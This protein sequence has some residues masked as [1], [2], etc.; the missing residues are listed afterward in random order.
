M[1]RIPLS[2]AQ[3]HPHPWTLL[4]TANVATIPT[5]GGRRRWLAAV[6]TALDQPTGQQSLTR[7][8]V[9]PATAMA[10]ATLDAQAADHRTGR[11]VATAHATLARAL[12]VCS[13][14]IQ[15]GRQVLIDLG[16]ATVVAAGRYLT[17]AERQQAAAAG[18][19]QIRAA[20]TRVLTL[21]HHLAHV[22]LPRRGSS[23]PHTSRQCM[24][25]NR[26]LTRAKAA[27]KRTIRP[28]WLQRLAAR[29]A[30]RLPWLAT[31]HIGRLCD[32]LDA[33]P[34]SPDWTATDIIDTLDAR[35]R[36]LGLLALPPSSQHHPA[37]LLAHQLADA[38][39]HDINAHANRL[40]RH[41]QH[42]QQIATRAQQIAQTRADAQAHAAYMADA[43]AR[44]R[45]RAQREQLRARLREVRLQRRG[46]NGNVA[47][48]QVSDQAHMIG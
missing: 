29:L 10:I 22:H 8:H 42:Q 17:T 23:T 32:A 33:L 11:S 46:H 19:H 12:R 37:A 39:A 15:R 43:A 2:Q 14:T 1:A 31:G 47:S 13:R 36:S 48:K 34:I 26:A 30:A 16:L 38:L 20:S 5:W 6:Q 27:T 7:H 41:A 4:P 28:I 9:A 25:T 35:N 18:R 3:T 24:D 44:G 45:I 40:T 21:P